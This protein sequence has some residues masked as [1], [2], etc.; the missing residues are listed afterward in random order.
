MSTPVSD[1]EKDRIRQVAS[2]LY[3]ASRPIR[4]LRAIAWP[5]QVKEQFFAKNARELPQVSYSPVDP[6]P[7][8]EAIREARRLIVPVSPIDLWLERQADSLERAARMLSVVGDH[9][10]FEYS[11]Q[12]YGEPTTPLRYYPVTPLELSQTICDTIDQL[13]CIE[14]D[15]APPEYHT[16]EAVAGDIE[17]AVQ[18]HFGEDAPRVE[19]VDKLSA[20][21]LATSGKIS[22][23]R[24]ARFTDRD[25]SQLLNHEA[26]IHVATSL[27]GKAQTH[28]PIL[29]AGHPNTTRTQE[30]LAVFAEIISGSMELDRLRRLADRVFAIQMAVEGADFLEVYRYF[31]GRVGDPDQAFENARR[32]FRGGVITG[33]APFT[34]DVV[35]LFGLLGVSN[36][37]RAFFAAG[38]SDC[39][40]LLFCGKLDIMD[41]PAL[42]ELYQMGLC[43][44][45]RYLPPWVSDPRY[46]LALLTYSIF[47]NKMSIEP[48]IVV[49]NK[50]LE[51]AP[52]VKL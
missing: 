16:A 13:V 49:A 24:D 8:L 37:I 36:A 22:I 25:A 30:G 7:T 26:Y 31:L 21:A 51:S 18:K 17:R 39:L 33:G 48:L 43:Q 50:I 14:M 29:A 10:F 47:M 6:Q 46:L 28:L 38:R 3:Q 2:L 45:P 35:Y 15:I 44:A 5:S 4:I 32:V 1:R 52:V 11:R 9:A 41:I 42:C 12:L 23:R 19:L 40:K 27:N 20:N 34:K